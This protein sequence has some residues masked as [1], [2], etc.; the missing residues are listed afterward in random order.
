LTAT[1]AIAGEWALLREHFQHHASAIDRFRHTGPATV[2]HMA[3]SGRNEVGEVLSSF[4]RMALIERHC[5]LCGCWPP[6]AMCSVS[7]R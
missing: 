7:Q 3:E 5:E 1:K 4:E 6:E 2:M